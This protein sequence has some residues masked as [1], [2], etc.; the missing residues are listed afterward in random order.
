MSFRLGA[1]PSTASFFQKNWHHQQ[2][3]RPSEESWAFWCCPTNADVLQGELG[4]AGND[5]G[6][7]ASSV[8]YPADT[9]STMCPFKRG[10]VFCQLSGGIEPIIR[11]RIVIPTARANRQHKLVLAWPCQS[12]PLS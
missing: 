7:L 10:L 9:K 3:V 8:Q 4:P 1:G 5:A 12:S 11:H 2:V 6:N